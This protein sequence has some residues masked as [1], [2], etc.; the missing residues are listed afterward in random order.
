MLKIFLQKL[1]Q[2]HV[3]DTSLMKLLFTNGFSPVTS[4]PEQIKGGL[5][6]LDKLFIDQYK[7]TDMIDELEKL[8]RS[9]ITEKIYMVK[10]M[11]ES[12]NTAI[13]H[14]LPDKDRVKVY[15]VQL[16]RDKIIARE[17]NNLVKLR[18][19]SSTS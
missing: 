18:D 16:Y 8:D 3:T 5:I 1:P 15:L 11:Q 6:R 9:D 12:L 7:V 10:Q 4:T 17:N 2:A 19:T 13:K 14:I